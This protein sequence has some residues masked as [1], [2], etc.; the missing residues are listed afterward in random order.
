MDARGK[1]IAIEG[2]DGSGKTGQF[3][4]FILALPESVKIGTLD[5]PRYG[6]P[7]SYFVQKYLSGKYGGEVGP[8][9]AS[10]FYALD[11]FDAKLKILQWFEEERLVVANRYV[12]SNMGYQG[13]KLVSKG[14]REKFYRWL[15]ALEYETLGI[16]K[17]D[18]NIVLHVP[19]EIASELITKSGRQKDIHEI[20]TA[21]QKR[22]EE[23]YLEIASL[24]PK[25]F[26][27][28]D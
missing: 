19:A 10:L 7:S 23:V 17:P 9:A 4:R 1:F 13:A 5:F 21:Y 2:T 27:V 18:L 26:R 14:E 25:D 6:E 15:Y 11:R 3:E 16:P 8:Y 24:F 28:I 12:A 20:D 22:A